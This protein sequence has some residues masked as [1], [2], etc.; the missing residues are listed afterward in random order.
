MNTLQLI[1]QIVTAAI[2]AIALIINSHQALNA[3]VFKTPTRDGALRDVLVLL[4]FIAL[5][6]LAGAFDQ[7]VGWPNV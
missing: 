6:L 1:A 4:A 3:Y 7:I 5:L 2:L